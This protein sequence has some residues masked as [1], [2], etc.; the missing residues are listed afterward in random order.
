MPRTADHDARRRQVAEAMLRVTMT[1][2]L[3]AAS[4]PRI[5]REAG[6]S[7]GLVQRYFPTKDDLLRY[8]FRYV[9]DELFTAIDAELAASAGRRIGTRLYRALAI[10]LAPV[11]SPGD[12]AGRVW[13][14]FLA[15][16]AVHEGLRE[17]H[18]EL[19]QQGRRQYADAL[20]AAQAAGDAAA[21]L[22]P[23]R[24]ARALMAYVDG[25]TLHLVLEPETM[26]PVRA[27][28][29]L[30]RYLSRLVRIEDEP[31]TEGD[32]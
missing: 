15:R 4:I 7:T 21:D 17:L 30:H 12:P 11:E 28:A 31:P 22:D 3:E 32:R 24:E 29:E 2:G 23:E 1:E 8:A 25:L 26:T 5:A 13:L 9:L 6:V 10:L 27:R 16:A 14:A 18:V 20:R 19:N